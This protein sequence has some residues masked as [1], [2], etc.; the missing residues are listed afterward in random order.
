[1]YISKLKI[2]ISPSSVTW[3]SVKWNLGQ[4]LGLRLV[5]D[6][7]VCGIKVWWRR[8][9]VRA[10]QFESLHSSLTIFLS[11]FSNGISWFVMRVQFAESGK[12]PFFSHVSTNLP[13]ALRPIFKGPSRRSNSSSDSIPNRALARLQIL[14]VPKSICRIFFL[15]M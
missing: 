7:I 15:S 4:M 11:R 9:R 3:F 8:N 13:L 5:R 12:A 1:M 2:R 6:K 14:F 10:T